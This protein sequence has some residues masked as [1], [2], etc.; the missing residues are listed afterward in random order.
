M[1]TLAVEISVPSAVGVSISSNALTVDLDD[2]RSV[3]V[4]ISWY[5]RLANGNK[6]E[7]NQWHLIGG[8]HGIHW[9]ALDE[10]ISIEG[11]ITGKP[12][13]ESQLSLGKWLK[14]RITKK[15]S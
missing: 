8:G 9:E 10:D 7:Q 3:S 4:P 14:S 15:S 12:S 6:Q 2:G 1:N 11:L 13:N 5:P